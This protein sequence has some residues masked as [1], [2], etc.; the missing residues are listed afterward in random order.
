MLQILRYLTGETGETGGA[1]G[2]ASAMTVARLNPKSARCKRTA[3]NF[4]HYLNG[5][6]L[7]PVSG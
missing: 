5:G 6:S 1:A 2:Q 7:P 3:R 4:Q